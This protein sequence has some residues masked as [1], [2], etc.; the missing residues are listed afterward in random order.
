MMGM[1]TFT[2]LG[3]K[4]R[5]DGTFGPCIVCGR[6]DYFGT[7]G[8]RAARGAILE[9]FYLGRA[10][11]QAGLPVRCLGGLGTVSFRMY[12]EGFSQMVEGWS[13]TFGGGAGTS[14]STLLLTAGWV[15]GCPGA[16]ILPVVALLDGTFVTNPPLGILALAPY[17][18]YVLQI[19]WMLRRIGDFGRW[20]AAVYPLSVLFLAGVFLRSLALMIV[21]GRVR[22]RGRE[23]ATGSLRDAW[24]GRGTKWG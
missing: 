19:R 2:P 10:F 17:V 5:P 4:V 1:H 12:P 14:I 23:I 7:G 18:A 16:A 6:E 24:W 9:D 22:W 13:K 8:H 15:A 21:K 20:I 11:M 3:Q